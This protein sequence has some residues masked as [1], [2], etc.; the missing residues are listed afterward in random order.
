MTHP[1]KIPHFFVIGFYGKDILKF[2][3]IQMTFSVADDWQTVTELRFFQR[4]LC[5]T[6]HDMVITPDHQ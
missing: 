4:D 3:N 5:N 1:Y 6:T 2:L